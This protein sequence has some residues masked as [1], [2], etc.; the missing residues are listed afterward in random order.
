MPSTTTNNQTSTQDDTEVLAWVMGHDQ[1]G[2][3][4]SC[5]PPSLPYDSEHIQRRCI[6]IA[7]LQKLVV[8]GLSLLTRLCQEFVQ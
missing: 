7:K 5:L 1:Q 3:M 4:V 2:N 6:T 8:F